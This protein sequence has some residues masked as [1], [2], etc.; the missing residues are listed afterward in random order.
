MILATLLASCMAKKDKATPG[1][2]NL[3]EP[4]VQKLPAELREISGITFHPA[5]PGT[6]YAVEDEHGKIYTLTAGAGITTTVT[7]NKKGDYEDLAICNNHVVV[8][9]SDGALFSFPVTELV[10][11][12]AEHVQ[13]FTDLLPAGEY[14]A[15]YADEETGRLYVLCK[16]CPG[17]LSSKQCS[18]FIL[19]LHRDG[20]I[21]ADTGFRIDVKAIE[22]LPGKRVQF[23]PSGLARH[24]FSKDWYIISSV[25]KLLVIAGTDWK[26]R[27]VYP[28]DAS[29]FNQPEGI[30]FDK[31]GNLFISSEAGDTKKASLLHFTIRQKT[32]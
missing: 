15:L 5:Q 28:L 31:K 8:L 1:E 13:S 9:Q 20:S 16:S 11:E 21:T 26:I 3:Q 12:K 23:K 14:E 10:K 32:K 17:D 24:P 25:N 29:L 4:R 7:F 27:Q 18:G 2:Y 30:A 22:A 19:Q 6:M